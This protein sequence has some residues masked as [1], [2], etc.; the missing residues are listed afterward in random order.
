[1][2]SGGT[3]S[4]VVTRWLGEDVFLAGRLRRM[5]RLFSG[6]IARFRTMSRVIPCFITGV[7]VTDR[8]QVCRKVISV[9]AYL[10]DSAHIPQ[11]NN[12]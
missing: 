6:R 7:W 8:R 10:V 11:D 12:R 9:F 3:P 5:S 2:V 4:G 1:M